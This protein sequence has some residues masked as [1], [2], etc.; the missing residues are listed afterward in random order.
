MAKLKKYMLIQVWQK[1]EL[2]MMFVA[3]EQKTSLGKL[4]FLPSLTRKTHAG[5]TNLTKTVTTQMQPCF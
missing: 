4:H 1:S 3:L 5:F 2:T